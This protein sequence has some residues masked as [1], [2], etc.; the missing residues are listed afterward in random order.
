MPADDFVDQL[1][2]RQTVTNKDGK[3]ELEGKVKCVTSTQQLCCIELPSHELSIS[4]NW[5]CSAWP[6][7]QSNKADMAEQCQTRSRKTMTRVIDTMTIDVKFCWSIGVTRSIHTKIKFQTA[8]SNVLKFGARLTLNESKRFSSDMI[9]NVVERAAIFTLSEDPD[10][11]PS[12]YVPLHR[13]KA[14]ST[15]QSSTSSSSSTVVSGSAGNVD[16]AKDDKSFL[17]MQSESVPLIQPGPSSSCRAGRKRSFQ[18]LNEPAVGQPLPSHSTK[19]AR[20]Q[21]TSPTSLKRK[22]S[23]ETDQTADERASMS[24][25]RHKSATE[26][27]STTASVG[28]SNSPAG[29][30]SQRVT[31]SRSSVYQISHQSV[32]ALAPLVPN[33]P[34]NLVSLLLINPSFSQPASQPASQAANQSASRPAASMNRQNQSRSPSSDVQDR[35]NQL[36]FD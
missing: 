34:F 31:S 24:S 30:S 7:F 18:S 15:V 4:Y 21:S 26:Q 16:D 28:F 33:A 8:Q 17:M 9:A 36:R 32:L 19:R 25:K 13:P 10:Q 27:H 14:S 22:S 6:V 23:S 3:K 29:T 5:S 20:Q 1:P 12:D 2:D 35:L 11:N